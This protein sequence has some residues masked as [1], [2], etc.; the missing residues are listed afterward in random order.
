MRLTSRETRKP[1]VDFT[2]GDFTATHRPLAHTPS[3]GCDGP[4]GF[5]TVFF[6]IGLLFAMGGFTLQLSGTDIAVAQKAGA[7]SLLSQAV[8][9]L[10]YFGG[11]I[12]L[13][14][15]GIASKMIAQAWPVFL[16]PLLAIISAM[17]SPDPALTLRR[18][19]ALL[20][21]DLFGL[22]LAS[23]LSYRC[24]LGLLI[25][26]LTLAILLSI[27]VVFAFPRYGVHQAADAFQS[28]HLGKWRGIFAHKNVLGGQ[29]A[30]ITIAM[31]VLYGHVAFRSVFLRLGAIAVTL[32]CLLAAEFGTGFAI[33]F[34]AI[35]LGLSLSLVEGQS[36][37][38][39]LGMLVLVLIGMLI[40]SL[41]ANNL[42]GVALSLLGK[43]P[44][45]TG[46]TEYWGYVLPFMEDHWILGYGYFAGFLSIGI[47][48]SKVTALDFGSSHNGYL[49]ILVSLG[50]VGL[51]FASIYLL[52]LAGLSLRLILKGPQALGAIK[53]FPMCILAFALQHNGVEST[54]LAG[55]SLVP[56]LLA[57]AAGM[58]VR[59]SIFSTNYLVARRGRQFSTLAGRT[60][61]ST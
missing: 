1:V 21:T 41:L 49:D 33:A 50:L 22:S 58:L 25:R 3:L 6:V 38:T 30:G 59:Q 10:F 57:I 36:I 56:L 44:D 40:L 16:L 60:Y 20:C 47:Q 26:A 29:V 51:F 48:I 53:T 31:L 14:R 27:I 46:R 32:L 12:I 54:I 19:F 24:C 37:R 34:L 39:R 17:W 35:V 7:G 28:E 15:T 2:A 9:S 18:S 43:S 13:I 42:A 45:L 61:P 55:N 8:L 11:L 23:A 5:L 4:S 52:W